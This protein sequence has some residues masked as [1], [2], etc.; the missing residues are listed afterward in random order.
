MVGKVGGLGGEGDGVWASA[1][2]LLPLEGIK[3]TGEESQLARVGT[4]KHTPGA[5]VCVS[6]EAWTTV[7]ENCV[8]LCSS[9]C[10]PASVG[11]L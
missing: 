7:G 10:R 9:G 8:E 1:C 4:S 6:S 11:Q 2:L 3:Y 5:Y